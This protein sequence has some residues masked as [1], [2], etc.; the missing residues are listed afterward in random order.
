MQKKIL[1]IENANFKNTL[2]TTFTIVFAE[3]SIVLY[4]MRKVVLLIILSLPFFHL[5]TAQ[6]D[7]DIDKKELHDLLE[8]VKS[9]L[10]SIPPRL[11]SIVA[12][13]ETKPKT[14][15]RRVMKY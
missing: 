4:P 7:T 15:L 12:S 8:I 11:K 6:N 14:I 13:L 5:S 3:S 2:E 1:N 9:N 10:I